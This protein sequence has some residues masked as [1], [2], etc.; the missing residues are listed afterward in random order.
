MNFSELPQE[1]QDKLNRERKELCKKNH[2]TPYEVVLYNEDGTR[3]FHA[4]RCCKVWAD[5]KGHYMPFGG[6]TYWTVRYGAVQFKNERQVIGRE[7]VLCDGKLYN[8]SKNG[9][10]IFPEVETKK[11]VIAIAKAIGIFTL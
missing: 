3:Y 8:R 5:T 11:E 10:E 4:R 7:Y 9:T 2:N 1:V 6:G